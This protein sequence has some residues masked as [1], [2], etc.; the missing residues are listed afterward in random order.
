M[1]LRTGKGKPWNVK[2]NRK[3][4]GCKRKGRTEVRESFSISKKR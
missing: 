4:N 1:V 3:G 2:N